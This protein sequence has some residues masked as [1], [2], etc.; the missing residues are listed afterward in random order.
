MMDKFHGHVVSGLGKGALFTELDWAKKQFIEKLGIDPHPGTLNILLTDDESKAKWQSLQDSASYTVYASDKQDC[1]ARC[2]PVFV[3]NQY[4]GAIVLP[5]I[6]YYPADQIEI[7]APIPLRQRL[8]LQDG[9]KV[10][11]DFIYPHKATTII[12]DLDGTLIDTIEAFYMLAKLTGD[13]FGIN[14]VRSHVY[15][16]LNHGL[17]YWDSVVSESRANRQTIIEELNIRAVELWPEVI[18]EHARVFP[19]IFHTLSTLKELGYTLAI[20]TGSGGKSLELLYSAGV[21]D[22][23]DAVVS[24]ADVSRRKPDP[25][26]LYLCLNSLGVDASDAVYVGD[27]SIDMQASRAAGMTA[28]AVLSGAGN[29]AALCTAGA[30]RIVQDHSALISLFEKR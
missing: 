6:D 23:F 12:F 28:V 26:G 29:S 8:S 9:D 16:L 7:I 1:D 19:D 21:R 2:Y 10:T 25:E 13:E 14:M 27:T 20:V 18:A 11:L 24:G 4:A 17:P 30:H 3:A 22:L 5:L 15:N